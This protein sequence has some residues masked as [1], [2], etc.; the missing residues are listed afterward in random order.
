M[1]NIKKMIARLTHRAFHLICVVLN[2]IEA[3]IYIGYIVF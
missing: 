2:R 3:M 1:F